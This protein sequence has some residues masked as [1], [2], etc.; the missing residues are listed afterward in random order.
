ME[1]LSLKTTKKEEF[2]DITAK[3]KDAVAKENIK[4]G[5]CCVYIPHT[6]AAVTIN[7]NA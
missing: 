4:R 2:I 1:T 5:L 6:T 3:V 7:E